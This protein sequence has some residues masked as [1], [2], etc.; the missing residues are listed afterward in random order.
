MYTCSLMTIRSA[1][2]DKMCNFNAKLLL[3]PVSQ[4]ILPPGQLAPRGASQPRQAVPGYLAPHPGYLQ[5]RG[6]GGGEA[7]QAGLS[8]P[9]PP[10]PAQHK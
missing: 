4:F 8:C 6:G 3:M 9:P 10:P 7:V 2:V 5:P 1:C